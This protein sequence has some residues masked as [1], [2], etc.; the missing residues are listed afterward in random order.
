[1]EN[2]SY[3][4]SFLFAEIRYDQSSRPWDENASSNSTQLDE[5]LSAVEL[6]K[7]KIC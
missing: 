5:I 2:I 1:M 3:F 7:Y 4:I 6:A